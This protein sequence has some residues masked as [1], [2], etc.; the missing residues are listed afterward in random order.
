MN[1]HQPYTAVIF[2]NMRSAHDDD[3]YDRAAARMVELAA[4][5]PGY[6]GIESVRG[7]DGCGITVSYWDS[8]ADARAWK[9]H[10]EHLATQQTGRH[11]WYRW[12]RL[13]VATVEREYGFDAS[14]VPTNILHIALPDDWRAAAASDDYRISTRGITLAQEGFIHCSYPNQ[15][16]GAANRF[17]GDLS[18]LLLLHIDTERVDSEIR[19][20]PPADGVEQLFPHI[21]G[22][23]PTAAVVATTAWHRSD[24]GTW[25]RPENV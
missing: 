24:D 20:E 4:E 2:T 18:E 11:S 1:D 15:L 21:Y 16:E 9:Q 19:I 23:I 5:Q 22:P 12:Y 14:S 8:D 17:Y 6:R 3:G 13:R 10:S 7:A 25:N